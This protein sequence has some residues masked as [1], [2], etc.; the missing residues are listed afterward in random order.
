[1]SQNRNY[2]LSTRP[3]PLSVDY[4]RV[5]VTRPEPALVLVANFFRTRLRGDLFLAQKIEIG[6]AAGAGVNDGGEVG[7]K[8]KRIAV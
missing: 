6:L 5:A 1:M 7:R 4:F 3:W 2:N 8:V